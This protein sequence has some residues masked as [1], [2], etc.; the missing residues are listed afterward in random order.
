[1][2]KVIANTKKNASCKMLF[3]NNCKKNYQLP[4]TVSTESTL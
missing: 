2:F 3:H 4:L 1:M